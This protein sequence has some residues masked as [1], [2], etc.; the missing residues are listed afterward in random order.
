MTAGWTVTSTTGNTMP[1]RRLR[2]PRLRLR[3]RLRPPCVA[4]SAAKS[5]PHQSGSLV[6]RLIGERV[7][8]LRDECT[9]QWP[10]HFFQKV[11]LAAAGVVF[12]G[13]PTPASGGHT[14][15]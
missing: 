8:S 11:T 14:P 5:G 15:P 2:L 13:G 12:V 3:C 10:V 9:G 6:G 1:V 7:K 4:V